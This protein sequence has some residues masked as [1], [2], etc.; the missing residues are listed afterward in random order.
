MKKLSIFIFILFSSVK[1]IAQGA[2]DFKITE[3]YI[4][5]DGEQNG[6]KDEYGEVCSWIEIENTSYTTHDIRNCFLTTNKK[7]L[8]K[9]LSAPE[10]EK[11]MSVIPSGDDRTNLKGKHRITFFADGKSNRGA[12]HTNSK[13]IIHPT[14]D[15]PIFIALYDGNAVDLLDSI[16]LPV[17]LKKGC[18]YARFGETWKEVAPPSITPNAPNTISGNSDKI[19]DWKEKDPYGIAM[20]IISMGIVFGCL[21]LL[22]VFFYIFGWIINKMNRAS[23]Y[24]ALIKLREQANRVVVIAKDGIET[25]GIEMENYVAAISLALHEHLGNMHD[26]ESGVITIQHHAT[27]WESK[28]HTLRHIP[29]VHIINNQIQQ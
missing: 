29:E 1:I 23:Q 27:E 7:V 28:E 16:T 20:T 19:K 14:I 24:K 25:K 2:H 22:F 15:K 12:L 9:N 11:L 17:S 10:R 3:V 18:S 4:A 26:I 13:L 5:Q 6:Y 8:D 21:L